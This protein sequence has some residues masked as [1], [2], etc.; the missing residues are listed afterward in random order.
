MKKRILPGILA[1]A[2]TLVLLLSIFL[3]ASVPALALGTTF[4]LSRPGFSGETY[5]H[6]FTAA[7]L[8]EELS[9]SAADSELKYLSDVGALSVVYP[10]SIPSS[11]VSYSHAD[12]VLTVRAKKYTYTSSSGITATWLP[13]SVKLSS[14]GDA[15]FTQDGE[16][17][18]AELPLS[19]FS[20]ALTLDVDYRNTVTVP[21]DKVNEILSKAFGDGKNY[22][23]ANVKY[24]SDLEAYKLALAEYESDSKE[25][26]LLLSEYEAS[27]AVYQ[28]YL[29]DKK[30]YDELYSEYRTYLQEL[31]A[32]NADL[33]K[34]NAYL[35]AIEKYKAD[36]SA[37]IASEEKKASL[38]DE[39]AAYESYLSMLE[40][41]NYRLSLVE[42]TKTNV[43]R[44]ER[45]IY[46]A[47]MGDTVTT[48]IENEDV[49]A[50]NLV[51][52]NREAVDMA[53]KAT[54]WLRVLMKDYFSKSGN[55]EKFIYYKLNYRR[56]RDNM[57][58]LFR[59]LDNL[60]ENERVR[61]LL[62]ANDKDEKYRILLAQLYYASLAFSDTAVY[63]FTETAVYDSTYKI[64][65]VYSP[66]EIIMNADYYVDKNT[67][68]PATGDVYPAEVAKPDY[69]PVAE[70]I[71][72]AEVK[73]PTAPVAVSEPTAPKV[74]IEPTKPVEP[75]APVAPNA[76]FV[77]GSSEEA[78]AAAYSRGELY[79]RTDSRLV[80]DY[81]VS[82]SIV[83]KKSLGASSVSVVYH[84]VSGESVGVV[85]LDSGSF[86]EI[87][88]VPT[89]PSDERANYV[90]SD[91]VDLAGNAVDL[92]SVT[93]DISVY[94]KF[95]EE[96]KHYTV[97]WVVDSSESSFLVPYGEIPVAPDSAGRIGNDSV[98][99]TFIGWSQDGT[100]AVTPTAVTSN[101]RYTALFE[102][103]YTV[104]LESGG[105]DITRTEGALYVDLKSSSYS[106]VRIDR[107]LEIADGQLVFK[108]AL[109]SVTVPYVE[110]LALRE[111]KAH[112]IEIS[113]SEQ[114]GYA[115][116]SVR[117]YDTEGKEL[118]YSAKLALVA[119]TVL[120]G[121][122]LRLFSADSDK[123]EYF[124]FN[125]TEN[126]AS[127]NLNTG[128][129]VRLAKENTVSTFPSELAELF[130]SAAVASPGE[131]VTL[132]ATA[133]E[134][135]RIKGFYYVTPDGA[136]VSLEGNSF[137]MPSQSVTVGV[138]AEIIYYTVSF[139]SDGIIIS[140]AKYRYG[141]TVKIPQN[142]TKP[143]DEFFSYKFKSWSPTI[144]V[145][146]A[147]AVYNAEF[148][149]SELSPKEPDDGLKISDG[150]MR[151]IVT[152]VLSLALLV[153]AVIPSTVI[154]VSL[155]AK[156]RRLGICFLERTN[157]IH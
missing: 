52:A 89:K 15:S 127:F 136:R 79:D 111:N 118:V 153:L 156:R 101:V 9:V 92:N 51:G 135:I 31:S 44:L 94:P 69:T 106:K 148:E 73:E 152:A 3:S 35:T 83:M 126:Q 7:D 91:W 43:S 90:F 61:D 33:E 149:S 40:L 103:E 14:G 16:E 140:T 77:A 107:L 133:P 146:T 27:Y 147:D 123:R 129:T 10:K 59:S 53:G 102:P 11:Y 80:S 155:F 117:L 36:Y 58:N 144:S 124:R 50:G 57:C 41:I 86:A 145:V 68:A 112:A 24:L 110:M 19:E 137:S 72:P 109:G 154:A 141:E 65:G 120:S 78:I 96:I 115:E 157:K 63:N 48:V 128:H 95:K 62:E 56:F 39:L 81:D 32:Y 34:Y 70:P 97:T 130:V 54:S 42:S 150:V 66:A 64:G 47:I 67:A 108:L 143:D 25:Y 30:V 22:Y 85:N 23:E 131:L 17:Y 84:D 4:D 116:Y 71:A 13:S 125:L 37:Y 6:I 113:F 119:T 93:S 5:N 100:T 55:E 1:A 46:D 49:I 132:S 28:K 99:Y 105:A 26:A 142:P 122:D 139:I 76:P 138:D 20:E 87:D 104:P 98:S 2:V 18:V 29:S 38:A 82:L 21:R 134:G 45:N 75:V 74:V 12:G 60:Y 8:F 88:Y 121:D 151:I 114:N